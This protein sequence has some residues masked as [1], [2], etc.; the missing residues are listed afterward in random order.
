MPEHN[1]ITDPNLH[2]PKGVAAAAINTVYV[3]NGAGSG[4]WKV[5]EEGS[6]NAAIETGVLAQ[7]Q[8]NILAGTL[9]ILRAETFLFCIIPD[10]STAH[11]L[12]IPIPKN[13]TFSAARLTLEGAI[14]V[15]N[16]SVEFKTAADVSMGVATILFTG[17][18]AGTSF[19]FTP[20]GN[21]VLT[22]PT[23]MKIVN[24]AGSTGAQRLFITLHFYVTRTVPEA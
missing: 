18:A 10:I 3:A 20:S 8:T 6:L 22:A 24:A 5:L 12:L 15:A 19:A 2:E 14:T 13:C 23:Y 21:N 11:T 4:T 17:S 7:A 9:S 16:A 1:T